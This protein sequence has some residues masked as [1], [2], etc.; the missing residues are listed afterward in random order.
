MFDNRWTFARGRLH[1]AFSLGEKRI[2]YAYI[3]KNACSAFKKMLTGEPH[4]S[5]DKVAQRFPFR[6]GPYDA[7]IFVWR[8][9]EERLISLYR[10]K[11]VEQEAAKDFLRSYRK[12]MDAEP[13]LFEDLVRFACTQADPHC[14][15]QR[16]HLRRMRYTHAIHIK[17]L[18]ETMRAIV[19]PEAD[20][21][22]SERSNTTEQHPV[23]V[24]EEARRM[25]RDHY[26]EDYRM[27][28]RITKRKG[29]QSGYI[30]SGSVA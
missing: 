9:P 22:F 8:D 23:H 24:S 20:P 27:I 5:V 26:A 28:S 11:I 3:R 1:L 14:F 4:V 7:S 2:A 6:S 25:I 12:V 19:G 29:R 15:T 16:S 30:G 13:G 18:H 17:D 10:N 21:H